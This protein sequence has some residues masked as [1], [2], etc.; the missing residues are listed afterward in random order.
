VLGCCV[1]LIT[2]YSPDDIDTFLFINS[3]DWI[4]T[5]PGLT[6]KQVAD[7]KLLVQSLGLQSDMRLLDLEDDSTGDTVDFCSVKV[8]GGKLYPCLSRLGK[9]FGTARPGKLEGLQKAKSESFLHQWGHVPVWS[10]IAKGMYDEVSQYKTVRSMY[11]DW[12]YRADISGRSL[13][14]L[15]A[16]MRESGKKSLPESSPA[17]WAKLASEY[18]TTIQDLKEIDRQAKSDWGNATLQ[19]AVLTL[20]IL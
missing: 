11:H 10:T 16:D 4:F 3:D 20:A 17:M 2:G 12:Q 14:S 19:L 8:C 7:V 6:R 13:D 5:T 18:R 9:V 1:E 15:I